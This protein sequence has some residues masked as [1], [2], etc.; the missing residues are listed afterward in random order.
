[1]SKEK[2][3]VLRGW[4]NMLKP[5]L[6]KGK[7]REFVENVNLVNG[8]NMSD[9]DMFTEYEKISILSLLQEKI[10]EN[11]IDFQKIVDFHIEN[12]E[13]RNKYRFYWRE[14]NIKRSEIKTKD[15]LEMYFIL[16]CNYRY[17]KDTEEYPFYVKNEKGQIL[18]CEDYVDDFY[19]VYRK[20]YD[21]NG[22]EIFYEDSEGVVKF[23]EYK[24]NV[25]INTI[26]DLVKA[27]IK[28]ILYKS[29][30]LIKNAKSGKGKN[31]NIS[32]AI[33]DP[34][35]GS[36]KTYD[37]RPGYWDVSMF[38]IFHNKIM[39]MDNNNRNYIKIYDIDRKEIYSNSL[40]A[41]KREELI[42]KLLND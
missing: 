4:I 40:I 21:S 3:S 27:K 29:D 12:K 31:I 25:L 41:I 33:N 15:E 30:V 22:N 37:I 36:C 9:L 11:S 2:S 1:M 38:D 17:K 14:N 23:F 24:N 42:T 7:I 5:F 32:Y 13:F 20:D 10:D 34:F 39:Y 26:T 19:F 6:V 18:S 8:L 35:Y 28:Y 16:N